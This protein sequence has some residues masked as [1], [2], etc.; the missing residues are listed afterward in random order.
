ML[1]GRIPS[2]KDESGA[3]SFY[4]IIRITKKVCQKFSIGLNFET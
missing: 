1:S 2:Y 3:V 4:A